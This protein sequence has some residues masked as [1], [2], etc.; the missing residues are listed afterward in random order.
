MT[1]GA[2][3]GG[4]ELQSVDQIPGIR[5]I[6]GI[7]GIRGWTISWAFQLCFRVLRATG[8]APAHFYFYFVI[9][10][11]PKTYYGFE[12]LFGQWPSK[13]VS[14]G[15]T[16]LLR[17]SLTNK[18]KH[19]ALA[20]AALGRC[21]GLGQLWGFV[22]QKRK[23]FFITLFVTPCCG[24]KANRNETKTEPIEGSNRVSKVLW[25]TQQD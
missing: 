14:N 21:G 10:L 15:I 24:S 19:Q 20:L 25:L 2:C 11:S 3:W 12:M 23:R 17:R 1:A 8:D 5:G 6:W 7:L 13:N 18:K 4:A 22:F 9:P 16:I